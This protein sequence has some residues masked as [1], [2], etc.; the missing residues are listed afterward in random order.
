MRVVGGKH[1]GRALKRVL[2]PTTR[3][4]ADMVKVAVF[5]ML[6]HHAQGV[7]LDL[8]AG[9]G[10]YGIE[11]I[12]RGATSVSFV[13]IDKDAI[14]TIKENLTM[15]N[16]LERAQLFHMPYEIYLKALKPNQTYDVIFLDPPYQ[17]H[18]Y[19]ELIKTLSSHVSENGVIVCESAKQLDL[20]DDISGLFKRKEKVYGIKKITIYQR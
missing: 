10:A 19:Q 12:S 7:V 2:K 8:F 4:T 1:R 17:L 5:N 20:P 16:E 14:K 3:E 15:L 6:M 11:A 9:S 13:D 18:V